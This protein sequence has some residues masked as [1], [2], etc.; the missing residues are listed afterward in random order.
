MELTNKLLTIIIYVQ[1]FCVLISIL[2]KQQT[3]VSSVLFVYYNK[4]WKGW[5]Y[6]WPGK[7]DQNSFWKSFKIKFTI[8]KADLHYNK[9]ITL[10]WWIAEQLLKRWAKNGRRSVYKLL[11]KV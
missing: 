10:K 7:V 11:L 5:M 3:K 2:F 4:F 9:V 6:K 1:F 8:K